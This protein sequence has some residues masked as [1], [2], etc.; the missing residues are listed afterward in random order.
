MF[1]TSRLT[2][3]LPARMQSQVDAYFE[4][5]EVLGAVKDPKVLSAIGPSGIRGLV[6]HR[7]KQA[8]TFT[9]PGVLGFSCQSFV[10]QYLVHEPVHP[11]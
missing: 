7:G 4:A 1:D 9:E 5:L 10:A 11:A 6:L 2:R 8:E 3:F